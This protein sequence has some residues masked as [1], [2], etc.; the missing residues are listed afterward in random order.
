MD[1]QA[2]YGLFRAIRWPETDGKAVCPK[3]SYPGWYWQPDSSMQ[4]CTVISKSREQLTF[5]EADLEL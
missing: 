2:A 4:R 5:A 3:L 1:E